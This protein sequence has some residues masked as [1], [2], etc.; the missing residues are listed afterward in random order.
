MKTISRFSVF[1]SFRL[2]ATAVSGVVVLGGSGCTG[3]IPERDAPDE[4]HESVGTSTSAITGEH[5][6]VVVAARIYVDADLAEASYA[7]PSTPGC[8]ATMIGPN[9]MMTAAHCGGVDTSVTF[10]TFRELDPTRSDTEAFGCRILINTFP[11]SDLT[12]FF[13]DPN[14]AGENPGDK[15]GY[16]DFDTNTVG[17]GQAVASFWHNPVVSLGLPWTLLYSTGTVTST[18]A[19]IWKPGP[20]PAPVGPINTAIGISSDLWIQP[21]GSGSSWINPANGR[22]LVGPTST[23]VSDG[24]GRNALSMQHYLDLAT[25][26]SGAAGIAEATAKALGVVD[27]ATR[28][29]GSVDKNDDNLFDVQQEIERARGENRKNVL[30]LGFESERRNALWDAASATFDTSAREAHVWP[31]WSG[32]AWRDVLVHRGL[33]LEAHTRY[34]VSLAVR[35]LGA[36]D[37]AGIEVALRKGAAIQAGQVLALPFASGWQTHSFELTALGDAPE[38]L[39]RARGNVEA[40]LRDLVLVKEGSAIDFDAHDTRVL[41]HRDEAGG[42]ALVLPDGRVDGTPNWAAH[43]QRDGAKPIATD[44]PL[45]SGLALAEGKRYHLCFSQKAVFAQAAGRP[46]AVVR[47]VGASG[48]GEVLR[49][50]FAPG[51]AW[52]TSC[53]PTFSV[54]AGGA[55]VQFGFDASSGPYRIDDVAVTRELSSGDIPVAPGHRP[56][57]GLGRPRP[58]PH[59]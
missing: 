48:G 7:M 26:P 34:R 2:L 55:E 50:A 42:R 38:L 44:W 13:C 5:P 37:P 1:S 28:L 59:P 21:G 4:E 58:F 39:I 40:Q 41:W 30:A 9:T 17:V 33:K 23:G 18:S 45:R 27:P 57:G 29:V 19:I 52:G 53:T 35:T 36:G 49:T 25:V 31:T 47:V 10:R 3:T 6:G 54:P 24:P 43:V 32:P 22:V 51:A 56:P 20:G 16:L 11:L 15:Y 12:L 8:S 14:A 46:G